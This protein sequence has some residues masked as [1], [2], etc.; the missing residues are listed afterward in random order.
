MDDEASAHS[1]RD[2]EDEEGASAPEPSLAARIAASGRTNRT[3]SGS[4][5]HPSTGR[6]DESGA[7]YGSDPQADRVGDAAA[8]SPPTSV[9]GTM[10]GRPEADPTATPGDE[11][12]RSGSV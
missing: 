12:D 3:T 7:T 8:G 10:A 11:S 4:V 6:V 1:R 2:D 9:G 5:D